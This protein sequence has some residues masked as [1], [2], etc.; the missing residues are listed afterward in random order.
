VRPV[1]EIIE[2]CARDCLERLAEVADAY[3]P[4]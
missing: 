3:P 4:R 2:E 1:A